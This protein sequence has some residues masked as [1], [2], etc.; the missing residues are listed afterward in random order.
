MAGGRDGT[1]GIHVA[2]EGKEVKKE[3]LLRGNCQAK[4]ETISQTTH[5]TH[6]TQG[7]CSFSCHCVCESPSVCVPHVGVCGLQATR[8]KTVA[9]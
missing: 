6:K 8:Q 7:G 9:T 4:V 3:F 1:V 2:Q 5:T